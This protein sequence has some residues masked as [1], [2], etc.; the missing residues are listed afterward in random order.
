M[1]NLGFFKE[2]EPASVTTHRFSH[3]QQIGCVYAI[4][5]RLADS[6]PRSLL[7][8][9]K[10]E[11]SAWLLHHPE[12]WSEKVEREYH[13]R[14]SDRLQH[15]L[16]AGHGSCPLRQPRLAEI[17]AAQLQNSGK[18]LG[19]RVWCFVVMPNHVHVL[20]ILTDRCSLPRLIRIWKGGSAR[21][22]NRALKRT[23]RL[24]QPDYFDRLV[25]SP[26]HFESCL[27]YIRDNPHRTHLPRGNYLHW[28]K[29][30]ARLQLRDH[31]FKYGAR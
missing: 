31:I 27:N 24:W 5:F 25:R 19:E 12:P 1:A 18:N 22:I 17:I 7:E 30:D 4:T 15:W 9:W 13:H 14:F 11:R 10:Q 20:V 3:W 23:G 8:R 16:D 6:L 2:R 29:E 28:E 26:H 21:K